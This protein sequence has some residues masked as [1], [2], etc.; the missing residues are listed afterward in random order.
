MEPIY[1]QR[2]DIVAY[3]NRKINIV[4]KPFKYR[5][6]YNDDLENEN[7]GRGYDIVKIQRYIKFLWF[8]KLKTIYKRKESD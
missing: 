6:Y 5:K 1:I 7:L 8:Y 2:G 3:R 4:N